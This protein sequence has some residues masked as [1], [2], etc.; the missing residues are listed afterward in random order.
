MAREPS[1]NDLNR[2]ARPVEWLSASSSCIRRLCASAPGGGRTIHRVLSYP[3]GLGG[4]LLPAHARIDP[5]PADSLGYSSY[6]AH[7]F[8]LM[9]GTSS[10]SNDES[11]SEALHTADV[12]ARIIS[13]PGLPPPPRPGRFATAFAD[14]DFTEAR[15]RVGFGND[16][17][18]VDLLFDSNLAGRSRAGPGGQRDGLDARAEHLVLSTS[19]ATSSRGAT[20]SA[21]RTCSARRFKLWAMT[22]SVSPPSSRA[23]RTSTSRAFARSRMGHGP[24]SSAPMERGDAP[25]QNYDY[26]YGGSAR[27]R[28]TLAYS[29]LELSTEM[30]AGTYRSFD[31]WD[32][33]QENVARNVH[34]SEGIVELRALLAWK[35]PGIPLQLRVYGDHLG[36]VSEMAPVTVRRWGIDC[37]ASRSAFACNA[38]TRG[39]RVACA[40]G[41]RDADAASRRASS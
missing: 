29:G 34:G 13:M 7:R 22:A 33:F 39:G 19:T 24:S 16:Q 4:H 8:D 41:A 31:R 18:L 20:S 17:W 36:R 38:T 14:G 23:P 28:G 27:A 32:R 6:F 21:S 1:I 5:L 11:R 10:A 30:F 25:S 26:T 9:L 40:G 37:S 15:A 35:L 3:L 12:N 2:D